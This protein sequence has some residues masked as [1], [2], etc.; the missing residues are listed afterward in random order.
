MDQLIMF[1][2]LNKKV[3][4]EKIMYYINAQTKHVISDQ[5]LHEWMNMH[6]DTRLVHIDVQLDFLRPI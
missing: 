2:K 6:S 4:S 5:D 1:H 3:R